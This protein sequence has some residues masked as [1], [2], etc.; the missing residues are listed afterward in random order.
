VDLVLATLSLASGQQEHE[1]GHSGLKSCKESG[2][3]RLGDRI[4]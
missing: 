3:D 4:C 1:H 2:A